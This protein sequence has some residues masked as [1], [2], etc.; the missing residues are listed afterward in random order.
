MEQRVLDALAINRTISYSKSG[1]YRARQLQIKKQLIDEAIDWPG[2]PIEGKYI[3][4]KVWECGSFSVQFGKYGK[5]YYRTERRNINDMFPAVFEN[6]KKREFDASFEVIFKLIEHLHF[7]GNNDSIIV[8]GCLFIRNAFLVDHEVIKDATI[9]YNPPQKAVDYLENSIGEYLG[10]PINAFLHYV[11]AIAWQEDVKYT[12]LGSKLSQDIGR[13]NNMLT[14][15]NFC[16]CLLGRSSFAKMLQNY[17]YGVSPLKKSII[18]SIFPE[19]K[20]TY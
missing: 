7:S 2:N 19:L 18:P 12:T 14:Y 10:V 4:T 3:Y 6:D 20:T 16:A 8:L 17:K 5:E 13:T 11:D 1:E 9:I 15:A